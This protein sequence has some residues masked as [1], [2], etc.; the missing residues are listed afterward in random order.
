M[1]LTEYLKVIVKF[2]Q[3]QVTKTNSKG[4]IVGLSGGIDSAVVALLMKEAFP[5]NHLCVIL[6]CQ[7][8]P[9]D[10]EYAQ[11]LVSTHDLRSQIVDLTSTFN[12]FKTTINSSL[13][14]EK[15]QLVLGNIKARL[16]MTTLYA[17]GQNENYLVVGTDNADER[18]IGYF[19]KYGDGGVDLLPIIHLLKQ[20]VINSAKLLGVIPEIIARK[21]TA[22]LFPGQTDESEMQ[23]KYQQL[24]QYLLGNK[25]GIPNDVI[26]R[27]ETMHK[28]SEHKRVPLP[29]APKWNRK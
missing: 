19:T 4:L 28:N 23:F 9:I 7:S 2:L 21:P 29:Q 3:T 27:I 20:D 17:L 1:V 24:D 11:K 10:V 8:D 13:N 18:H 5:N 12:T 6:P 14:S 26:T 15:S 25:T 22:S 16:R